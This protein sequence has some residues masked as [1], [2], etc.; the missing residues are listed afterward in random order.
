MLVFM[1]INIYSLYYIYTHTNYLTTI[2]PNTLLP[3]H[4]YM[5]GMVN[6]ISEDMNK[7]PAANKQ[8]YR[9]LFMEVFLFS[10]ILLLSL[11]WLYYTYALYYI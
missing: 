5:V 10:L 3:V 8:A 2:L 7:I 1:L 9:I 11:Y 6:K 4:S